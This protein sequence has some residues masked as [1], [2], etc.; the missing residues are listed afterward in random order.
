MGQR[1]FY[2]TALWCLGGITTRYVNIAWGR[3]LGI[4]FPHG[5]GSLQLSA[6]ATCNVPYVARAHGNLQKNGARKDKKDR[7]NRDT[8]GSR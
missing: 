5:N 6:P 2:I 1:L 3:F 4:S 7:A 8:D